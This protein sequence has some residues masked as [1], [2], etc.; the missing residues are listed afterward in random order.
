MITLSPGAKKVLSVVVIVLLAYFIIS[1]P[2]ES[3]NIVLDLL[4]MLREGAEAL[5]TFLQSLF[6]AA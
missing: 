6:A 1:R 3:A 4:N 5:I 2:N